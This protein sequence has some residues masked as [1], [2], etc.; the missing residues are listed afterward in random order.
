VVATLDGLPDQVPP[1]NPDP[2]T[3]TLENIDGN[4][5]VLDIGDGFFAFYAHMKPG[6]VR[7][8]VG[9]K[10]RAGAVLGLLGNSGNSSAPHLHFHVMDGPSV[11]GSEGVP[12]VLR[13]F[14]LAGKIPD[15][16]GVD[17][18]DADY[19]PFLLARPQP[20]SKQF[21][22]RMDVVDFTR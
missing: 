17:D 16:A 19:R 7:V 10:V 6:S 12:H 11:L 9:Q 1:N 14:K 18:P 20:R 13:R 22:L 15:D 4:H 5:V 8:R 3:I 21:P 2:S